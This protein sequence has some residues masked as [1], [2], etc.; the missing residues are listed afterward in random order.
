MSDKKNIDHLFQEKFQ[1]FEQQPNPELW[2]QI[3]SRLQR[4]N[5]RFFSFWWISSG[6]A[7]LI[8]GLFI[9]YTQKNKSNEVVVDPIITTSP[10]KN[11]QQETPKDFFQKTSP[12]EKGEIFITGEQEKG[13]IQ[14]KKRNDHTGSEKILKSRI[15]HTVIKNNEQK[16]DN[17]P[18]V[19]R[20]VDQLVKTDEVSEVIKKENTVSHNH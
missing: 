1:H 20:E 16:K 17:S 18:S 11:P 10:K 9:L 13:K 3:E 7:I 15:A 2:Y 6:A 14:H 12:T 19:S 5:K 8:V 4:K